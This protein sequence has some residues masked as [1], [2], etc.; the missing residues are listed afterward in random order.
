MLV[1]HY[2]MLAMTLNTLRVVPDLPV[3]DTGR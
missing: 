1:G 2:E 3:K